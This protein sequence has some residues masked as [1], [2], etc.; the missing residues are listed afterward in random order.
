MIAA[1]TETS[2]A[3]VISSH[4]SSSGSA[5][6]ARAIATR[7]RSPPE[8]WSGKR[9]GRARGER[10]ALEALA[11]RGGRRRA[12]PPPKQRELARDRLAD[13]PP[14]VQRRVRVLE[15]VLDLAPR[16]R[17]SARA[18]P[19]RQRRRRRGASRRC[20]PC[21]GRRRSA[22]ASSCRSPTRRRAPGTRC[23]GP[24]GRCRAACARGAV[25][26]VE[27][28]A[29]A[30]SDARRRSVRVGRRA[31]S[32]G[33]SS[34]DL[35]GVVAAHRCAGADVGHR[36]DAVAAVVRR[37]RA[38]RVEAAARRAGCP[39]AAACPGCRPRARLP[40]MSGTARSSR[41]VYGWRGAQKI[42][43]RGPVSTIRPAY[44]TA[45]RSASSATTARSWLT[46]S[47]ATLVAAA[48]V[49]DRLEHAR[50]R[51]DVEAGRRLVAHDHRGRRANAIAIATRCCWP[52]ESWCG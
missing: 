20:S 32:G 7:W 37:Q 11:T 48:Q 8:S 47:A 41:R 23:G 17:R 16:L 28:A 46:Y 6:S 3:E 18:R 25:V 21:A 9:F 22:R 14:R 15:D 38:A 44:I 29:T 31:P 27:A 45:T 30:S 12:R 52:P 33:A 5:A 10:D 4:T 19:R 35:V 26:R 39:A 42:R 34:R 24:R 43:S 40:A 50:L 36:R 13:R 1:W 51:R 49:A 2:S